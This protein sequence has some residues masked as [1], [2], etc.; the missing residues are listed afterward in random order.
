MTG[1][2]TPSL[3]VARSCVFSPVSPLF[4]GRTGRQRR[5]TGRQQPYFARSSFGC[6][7]PVNPSFVAAFA[8]L[9]VSLWRRMSADA[10][11]I[12]ILTGDNALL[13]TTFALAF[14]PVDPFS[15]AA[16]A[17]LRVSFPGSCPGKDGSFFDEETTGKACFLLLLLF[18]F[19]GALSRGENE[20]IIRYA[21]RIHKFSV[22]ARKTSATFSLY[23]K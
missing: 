3:R 4:R 9:R 12:F 10:T 23:A 18:H 6:F 11:G 8:A 2:Q 17:A 22:P 7:L 19:Q 5:R 1:E 13:L 16:F 14:S 20:L 21:R 15:V